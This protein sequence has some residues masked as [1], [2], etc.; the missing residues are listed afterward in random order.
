MVELPQ[1]TAAVLLLGV[2]NLVVFL[3]LQ[4]TRPPVERKV[5]EK[6]KRVA[7]LEWTHESVLALTRELVV[8]FGILAFTWVCENKPIFQHEQKSH[9]PDFF[10]FICLVILFFGLGSIQH[11]PKMTDIVNRDQTEEWKGWMQTVFL[12][13]HYFHASEVYNVVRVMISCYVW[14]TGFGNL[15]F[16]YTKQDYG[17][18][19]FAQMMW[20]L[21]FSVLFLCLL[22]NNM[23]MLYYICPLHTFYFLFT[24]A[25]MRTF[26]QVNYSK[27]GLRVKLM[28]VGLL[29]YLVWEFDAVFNVVFAFLPNDPHPGAA[30]GAY[31]IRYEWHFRSGLDHYSTFFGMM[32]ALNF[33]QAT[34]WMQRVEALTAR[35][36]VF[37]KGVGGLVLGSAFVWWS[38]EILPLPKLE[39]N[40][41]NPYT[42]MIPL[43][44]Y[45]YFRN[46]TPW[47][48]S[49]HLGVL[50]TIG[51]YTL[52][53]Y[54]MQH[55][56]WLTSNAKTVLVFVP[57]YP[58]INLMVVTAVYFT[59]ARRLY[60][61]TMVT[62][63]MLIPEDSGRALVFLGVQGCVLGVA[64]VA[65]TLLQLVGLS[66]PTLVLA[67]IAAGVGAFLVV[68]G[69]I[70]KNNGGLPQSNGSLER[71]K[72]QSSKSF[73]A[74]LVIFGLGVF[75]SATGLVFL[76]AVLP[77]GAPVNAGPLRPV[78]HRPSPAQCA[79]QVVYDVSWVDLNK[80]TCR[81]L[82]GPW[83]TSGSWIWNNHVSEKLCG[84]KRLDRRHA[85]DI[86]LKR[87]ILVVGDESAYDIYS[88]LHK[89]INPM[90]GRPVVGAL[91]D[92]GNA[93]PEN[94]VANLPWLDD[95]WAAH[96][97]FRFAPKIN[98]LGT[99]LPKGDADDA[100]VVL[101]STWIED[102]REG[103]SNFDFVKQS[104]LDFAKRL[105]ANAVKIL[106]LPPAVVY[107]KQL[108]KSA[109]VSDKSIRAISQ[110]LAQAANQSYAFAMPMAALT[111][112]REVESADGLRFS[113]DIN[114]AAAQ[115]IMNSLAILAP[116]L[117]HPAEPGGNGPKTAK[118][119]QGG[120]VA[121]DPVLGLFT[122][123]LAGAI[124]FTMDNYAGISFAALRCVKSS[125]RITWEDAVRELHEK[126]GV[127][128][129]F[130]IVNDDDDGVD[131]RTEMVGASP[132]NSPSA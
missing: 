97:G 9:K 5:V 16:F 1:S 59:I 48:R 21:N 102:S 64:G 123:A 56:V 15:S 62:R 54:L 41:H 63:A 74:S 27:W 128:K 127:R 86:A 36:Q 72:G 39:F 89:L 83:C 35:Q 80:N 81:S 131:E 98:Q 122:L 52:E 42:F 61:S 26:Q 69:T 8:F 107:S 79:S 22:M 46:L 67:G 132:P 70:Y 130:V 68:K 45:L 121:I 7:A 50:A 12:L 24:F 94:F 113:P 90:E 95:S 57:G 28:A 126:I 115:L 91:K 118:K 99:V 23:Y 114:D 2:C 106:A 109:A 30:V 3:A 49:I 33:P 40:Q 84:L 111:R 34:L 19:R 55:H 14:M 125:E 100:D 51:K 112:G 37:V 78:A 13:Y 101:V 53:T 58:K 85:L 6:G 11:H 129:A 47:L 119:G 108:T 66:A 88:A 29:I 117:Q 105:P 120:G 76:P 93:R 65:A 18:V 60:R 44:T 82:T 25:T 73:A 103:R 116:P 10:W 77:T 38:T 110:G 75:A 31:G 124:L 4:V 43:L 17:F 104:A 92:S 96:V 20:R 71:H 87:K 32:F